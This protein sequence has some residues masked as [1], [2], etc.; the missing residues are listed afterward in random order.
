VT[1]P[2]RP[3]REQVDAAIAMCGTPV[4]GDHPAVY[5]AHTLAVEVTAWRA[6]QE[7][8]RCCNAQP[9]TASAVTWS[10]MLRHQARRVAAM[11]A[12]V[13]ALRAELDAA[14][15]EH[16]RHAAEL[17]RVHDCLRHE[18]DAHIA[19]RSRLRA[20]LAA[21]TPQPAAGASLTC[22]DDGTSAYPDAC[23]T[24]GHWVAAAERAE[25]QASIAPLPAVPDGEDAAA[26]VLPTTTAL[27]NRKIAVVELRGLTACRCEPA[28]RDRGL[29]EPMKGCASEYREDVDVLAHAAPGFGGEDVPARLDAELLRMCDDAEAEVENALL[30]TGTRE[31]PMLETADVRAAVAAALARPT[32]GEGRG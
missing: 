17:E 30:S 11:R 14:V 12:E 8:G 10:R 15:R 21:R 5:R 26:F 25:T 18:S 13:R 22:C 16:D 1:A 24:C 19:E 20:A 9:S 2:D 23:P 7:G 27:T 4:S 28:W 6:E 32:G 31:V 3:T 29:H